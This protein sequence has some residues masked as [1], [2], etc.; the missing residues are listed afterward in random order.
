LIQEEVR[1][2]GIKVLESSSEAEDNEDAD[3]G[4]ED[5]GE[6]GSDGQQQW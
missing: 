5:S 3:D 4:E 2:K 1:G 6:D